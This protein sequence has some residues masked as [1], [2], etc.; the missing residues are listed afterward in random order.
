MISIHVP[1]AGSD[2]CFLGLL[3]AADISIHAPLAGSDDKVSNELRDLWISI[4]VPLAGSDP[5][6]SAACGAAPNFNPRSPCGERRQGWSALYS[7]NVFQSTFP[8]RGATH[9]STHG[10]AT[11]G[12]QSTFPLRGATTRRDK[13]AD[14]EKIS[15]H[16]PLAGSDKP[17]DPPAPPTRNF[18]PRSPCGERPDSHTVTAS[19]SIFQST[20]PLR[21]AT[22][23]VAV[24]RYAADISIHVPLA[25][26]DPM[27]ESTSL[28][29][30]PFQ[31]TL[32]LRGA[33]W[34]GRWGW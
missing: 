18:N 29:T 25:G 24:W 34:R 28:S 17:L 7:F 20:F 2:G 4:H 1:L 31:S 3:L 23:P 21:G 12:F 16:V 27:L 11:N 26:S 19:G 5:L 15:I 13:T 33:T 6:R 10:S 30:S 22:F 8:L 14:A 9:G 32:P